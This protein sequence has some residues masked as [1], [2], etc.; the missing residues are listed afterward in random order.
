MTSL[1]IAILFALSGAMVLAGTLLDRRNERYSPASLLL[2]SV[3]NGV[4]GLS[5]AWLNIQGT[6]AGRL[7]LPRVL[8]LFAA[9]VFLAAPVT[10][11]ARRRSLG[12][13]QR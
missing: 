9:L 5:Q 12:K 10:F 3:C 2:L 8:G 1:P 4:I 11:A 6:L 7:T 13:A